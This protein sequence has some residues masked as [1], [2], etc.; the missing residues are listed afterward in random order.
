MTR[1]NAAHPF[2][3][4]SEILHER[5]YENIFAYGG[6]IVFDNMKGFLTSKKYDRLL[7]DAY[8][9]K[10][11]VFAKWGVPDHVVF[12]RLVTIIDTLPRPFNLTVFTLSNHEPFDLPDSSVQRYKDNAD[13]SRLY[14]VQLYADKAIGRFVKQF[15]DH[16]AFDSTIF[17]FVSDHTK[18]GE[19]RYLLDPLG[20]Q[21]PLLIY[22]PRTLGDSS[23][24]VRTV[25][26]QIDVLPTLMGILG[27][28]YQHASWGRNMLGVDGEGGFAFIDDAANG[29]MIDSKFILRD[30]FHTRTSLLDRLVE[31]GRDTDISTQNESAAE[32]M[33]RR[34]RIFF[35]VAD[36]LSSPR[37]TVVK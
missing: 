4:L 11:N 32:R 2:V 16:S 10:E 27:G 26:G 33:K 21:I 28:E 18:R 3:A 30:E 17:V 8:F 1:Y 22:A 24:R 23:R 19:D 13:T 34:L 29:G 14:N 15:K 35:Q 36:Q 31:S 7:D 37:P 6:D 9:G 12:D 5:G 25:G 20:F